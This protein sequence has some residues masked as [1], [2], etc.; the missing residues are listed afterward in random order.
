MQNTNQTFGSRVP[1]KNVP[2]QH[3]SVQYHST[4]IPSIFHSHYTS[5]KS[6]III[7]PTVSWLHFHQCQVL[8]ATGNPKLH[9]DLSSLI[10]LGNP[11]AWQVTLSLYLW[12]FLS[13]K[14]CWKKTF[15]GPPTPYGYV[16]EYASN[17]FEYTLSQPS[18]SPSTCISI[19]TLLQMCTITLALLFKSSTWLLWLFVCISYSRESTFLKQEMTHCRTFRTGP[20]HTYFIEEW[21]YIPGSWEWM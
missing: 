19:P 12:A 20:C 2:I 11:F 10:S 17:G 18:Y 7:H 16:P 5:K 21:N 1:L 15:Q 14:L 8:V 6:L 4:C 3:F 13:Q 9:F